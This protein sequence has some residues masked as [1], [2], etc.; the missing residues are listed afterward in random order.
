MSASA[1][2]PDWLFA[3]GSLM[4]RPDF[5]Y[6]SRVRGY[7]SGWSRRFWQGSQDH[8]GVPGA[9]GRVVTLVAEP[10]AVCRGLAYRIAPEAREQV[11]EQVDR[12]ESGGYVRQPMTFVSEDP[13]YPGSVTAMVYVADV[14]NPNFLGAAPLP[15]IAAQV[16]RARGPSGHNLDYVLSLADSLEKLQVD[17]PHVLELARLLCA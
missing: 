6:E 2:L 9:P 1:E 4:W 13:A 5:A 15:E 17:D 8:R 12:R 11:L 7:I 3:Y 14:Q 10:G 16:R